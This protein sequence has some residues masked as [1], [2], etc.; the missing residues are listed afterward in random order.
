[1]AERK[2]IPSDTQKL[3]IITVY[4]KYNLENWVHSGYIC[5]NEQKIP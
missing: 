1:M 4:N 2:G 3:L 5:K